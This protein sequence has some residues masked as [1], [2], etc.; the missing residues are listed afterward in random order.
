LLA[1]VIAVAL[2]SRFSIDAELR[3]D[4][5]IYAYGGQQ[6]AQGVRPYVRILDP[7]TPLAR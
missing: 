1:L 3:R 2:F 7:K 4:E 6:L 5:A